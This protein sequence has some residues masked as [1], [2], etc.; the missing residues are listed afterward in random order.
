MDA[1]LRI[2]CFCFGLLAFIFLSCAAGGNAWVCYSKNSYT[3]E[4]G[5]WKACT[6]DVCVKIKENIPGKKYSE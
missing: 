5:L 1:V 6:M 2:L 3:S 4:F